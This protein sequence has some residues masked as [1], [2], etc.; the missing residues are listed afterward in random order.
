MLG[1]M[2]ITQGT[3]TSA[4]VLVSR[5]LDVA[6]RTYAAQAGIRLVDKP[7]ALYQLLVLAQ[8]LSTRISAD[9]AL[10]AAHELRAERLTTPR[11]MRDAEHL[12]VVAAL[13]RARYKRYDEITAT[14]LGE[15]AQAVIDW[16]GGDL[17]SLSDA[18]ERDVGAAMT[19]LQEF[20]GIGPVG[21]R[22]FVREV[23]HV[24]P[25]VRPY[26]DARV[27]TAADD[28]GLPHTVG[29]LVRLAG[30][31]DLSS[32]GAALVHV[33]LDRSLREVVVQA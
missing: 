19:L 10:A 26:A 9:V 14:R 27:L 24:W 23:Q 11:R 7:A 25:W 2:A 30:T 18:A 13:G 12:R 33:S 31:Q 6:G 5:L 4:R 29:Q 20:P 22:I 1:T 8:L 32:L 28:L 3:S 17:R 21:S 16:Y 15:S